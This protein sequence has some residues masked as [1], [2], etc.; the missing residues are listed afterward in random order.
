M[1]RIGILQMAPLMKVNLNKEDKMKNVNKILRLIDEISLDKPDII[2]M[3]E[4]AL[5]GPASAVIE[6]IDEVA[7]PV[8]GPTTEILA[9]KAREYGVYLVTLLLEKE[10]DKFFNTAV[11]IGN[12][13]SICGKYRKV[14]PYYPEKS[15]ISPGNSLPVFETKFAKI[16][17]LICFDNFFPEAARTLALKGAQ[18]ILLPLLTPEQ[19]ILTHHI[20]ARARAIENQVYVVLVNG[21]GTHPKISE[22]IFPGRSLIAY[23]SGEILE[24][25]E[26]EKIVTINLDLKKREKN[27][28]EFPLLSSRR[29]EIYEC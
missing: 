19:R 17:I 28:E 1:V 16:G 6:T 24:L 11:L 7:E 26:G 3:P 20:L 29:P 12:D 2:C 25:G 23:P 27:I 21:V 4:F 10:G 15:I 8:P 13:G 14:H 9:K 5:T 22:W 18:I